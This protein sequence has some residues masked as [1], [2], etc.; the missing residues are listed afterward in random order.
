MP[1]ELFNYL[2]TGYGPAR[3]YRKVL[4]GPMRLK[5][6]LLERIDRE[7]GLRR[8]RASSSSR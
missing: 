2:T 1:T 8:R 4:P 3:A 7:R 5:R 6:A